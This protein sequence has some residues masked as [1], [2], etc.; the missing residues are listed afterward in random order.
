MMAQQLGQQRRPR[1]AASRVTAYTQAS[2]NSA[3]LA[4]G[5]QLAEPRHGTLALLQAQEWQ[6][7]TAAIVRLGRH[8]LSSTN[9]QQHCRPLALETGLQMVGTHATHTGG[10]GCSR[11]PGPASRYQPLAT[12]THSVI[13][14]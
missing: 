5:A 14:V 6:D 2:P 11:W 8:G 4:A 10:T 12:L 1:A 13:T 3:A 7:A 9:N